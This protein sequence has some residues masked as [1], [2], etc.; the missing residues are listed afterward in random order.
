LTSACPRQSEKPAPVMPEK[1]TGGAPRQHHYIPRFLLSRWTTGDGRLVRYEMPRTGKLVHSRRHPS[2]VGFVRDLYRYPGAIGLEEQWLE[3][4]VFQRI[5]DAA[6]KVL[7]RMLGPKPITLEPAEGS[8]WIRFMLS[9]MFRTPTNLLFAKAAAGRIEDRLMDEICGHYDELRGPNDPANYAE[10]VAMQHPH[11]KERSA[12]EMLPGMM[13]HER[14]GQYMINMRWHVMDLDFSCPALLLSDD[15]LAR[16]NGI[17]VPTGHLAM[18][19]SPRRL[20][21]LSNSAETD[22]TLRGIGV[23]DLARAMN[24]WTVESAR[25]FVAAT[26]RSQERFIANRFGQRPKDGIMANMDFIDA[27]YA[28]DDAIRRGRRERRMSARNLHL[29]SHAVDTHGLERT[30]GGTRLTGWGS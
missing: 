17:G 13:D 1:T 4:R 16:T 26:D 28:D 24:R 20:L 7:T 2:E 25:R 10:F 11:A 8:A 22:A 12:L 18:P 15:P 21:V 3:H 23:R 14:I 5:D 29:H 9:L 30:E 6:A 27:M 19:I